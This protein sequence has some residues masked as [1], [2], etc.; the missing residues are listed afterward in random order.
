MFSDRRIVI[1]AVLLV[2][3]AIPWLLPLDWRPMLIGAFTLATAISLFLRPTFARIAL[4]VLCGVSVIIFFVA[5]LNREGID[6]GGRAYVG[7][8]L[9]TPFSIIA[10]V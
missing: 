3:A 4:P 10:L 9:L 6:I 7:M 1:S 5:G 2:V 8:Q